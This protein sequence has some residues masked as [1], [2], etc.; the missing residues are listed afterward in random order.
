LGGRP[1]RCGRPFSFLGSIIIAAVIHEL[2]DSR[3]LHVTRSEASAPFRYMV[4]DAADEEE[5]YTLAVATSPETFQPAGIGLMRRDEIE[6]EPA[7]A[8]NFYVTVDYTTDKLEENPAGAASPPQETDP[9]TGEPTEGGKNVPEGKDP[10]EALPREWS[11]STGGGT[12]HVTH[13]L[14]TVYSVSSNYGAL[15]ATHAAAAAA[16]TTTQAAYTAAVAATSAAYIAWQAD[17]GNASLEGV[18]Y[19]SLASQEIA[20]A[21]RDAALVAEGVALENMEADVPPDYKGAINA[22]SDSV[23]GVDIHAPEAK[24]QITE[25]VQDVTFGRFKQLVWL[26][27]KT[28]FAEWECFY[29][30][31]ALYLGSDGTNGDGTNKRRITHQFAYSETHKNFVV[32]EDITIPLKRGWEYLWVLYDHKEDT[33]AH[34][35]VVRPIAA[36]VE[37]VYHAIDFA[38]ELRL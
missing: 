8:G 36:Y 2:H 27:C 23:G 14:D 17:P 15:F 11:W 32:N 34:K 38:T 29:P 21:A 1:F 22:G 35:T 24:F 3:K 12:Q 16:V 20:E 37:K 4:R 33:A 10:T 30:C 13:S 18:Y 5:A 9:E 19:S 25:T 26:G 31:E 28:N 6:V 7:G